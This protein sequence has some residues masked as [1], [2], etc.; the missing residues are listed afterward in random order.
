M[1]GMT[2]CGTSWSLNSRHSSAGSTGAGAGTGESR[3]AEDPVV[4]QR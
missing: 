3:R 2:P 1:G 4:R